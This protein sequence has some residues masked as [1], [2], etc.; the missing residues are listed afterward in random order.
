MNLKPYYDAAVT[1][2]TGVQTILNEM[3]ALLQAG[4]KAEALELREKLEQA[5]VTAKEANEIYTMLRDGTEATG[6]ARKF[7]PAGG[8]AA[9]T[10]TEKSTSRA[11]FEQMEP[12][13]RMAFIKAGGVVVDD[14]E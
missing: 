10:S 5:K 1:A 9:K 11:V 2:E 8:A 3:D 4:K 6:K 12:A 14:K 7:V 13:D